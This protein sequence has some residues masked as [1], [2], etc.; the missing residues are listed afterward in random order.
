M[1]TLFISDLHLSPERPAVTGAFYRFLEKQGAK[2]D[3]LYILGDLF[4]AW[5]GDD[6][7]SP[8]SRDVIAKLKAYTDS[9]KQ[10]FFLHGNRDFLVGKRFARETSCTL[11]PEHKVIDLYGQPVLLLHGDT[12]CIE[13]IAYQKFRWKVRNPIG[14]WLLSHLPLKKRLQIASDWRQKSMNANS[15]KSSNI[16][17]VTPDEAERVFQKYGVKRM[18]HGHTHRPDRHAHQHGE[19]I[20]LGDWEANGWYLNASREGELSLESFPI[21]EAN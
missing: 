4:E 9:G 12:L 3:A 5:I 7:P 17:D 19:R 8:L 18:I 11:L 13:D 6:D 20:V 10:L 14:T 15:N 16:M 2:A 21:G 1:T